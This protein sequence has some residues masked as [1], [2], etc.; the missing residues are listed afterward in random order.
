MLELDSITAGTGNDSIIAGDGADEIIAGDGDN[1][2]DGGAGNDTISATTGEDSLDGGAGDDTFS[3]AANNESA[4]TIK[5]GADTDTI[6]YSAAGAVGDDD[7][8]N[9]TGIEQLTGAFDID[10]T[11]STK[12]AAA[13]SARSL[14]QVMVVERP[15]LLHL[16]K[17]SRMI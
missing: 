5:G 11:L 10:Y 13:E 4:D 12:A 16:M 9:I 7:F 3:L 14:L 17:T 8:T 15:T 2:V 6:S 1:I